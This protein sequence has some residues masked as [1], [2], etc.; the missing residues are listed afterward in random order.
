MEKN[1]K[2]NYFLFLTKKYSFSPFFSNLIITIFSWLN[3]PSTNRK[4]TIF[5]I[6]LSFL[7]SVITYLVFSN[8]LPYIKTTPPIAITTLTIDVI[9]LFALC[10]KVIRKIVQTWI[11]R[12]K[13]TV[14]AKIST[15]FMLTFALL[16]LIP[17]ITLATFSSLFFN[18]GMKGWFNDKILRMAEQSNIVAEAYLKEYRENIR[19]DALAMS[20]EIDENFNTI[21]LDLN[22]LNMY[23]YSQ[24]DLRELTEAFIFKKSGILLAKAGFTISTTPDLITDYELFEAENGKIILTSKRKD[25]VRALVKLKEIQNTYLSIGRF[26]D[27][28]IIEQIQNIK[29]ASMSYKKVF[30][31]RKKIEANFYMVF[32]LISLLILLI[33]I[34]IG[35]LF[36]DTLIKPITDLIKTSNKIKSGNLSV[37]VP[38][39]STKDEMSLLIKTF[40]EMTQKLKSQRIELKKRERNAAWSDIA[41]RIAH[42]I[43]NPLTPI[44]LSAEYLK[45]KSKSKEDKSYA[46]TII[47]KVSSIEDMVNEF[48]MFAK[49]PSPKF[50]TIKLNKLCSDLILFHKKSNKKIKFL[51]TNLNKVLIIKIDETQ[52]SMAISNLIQNSIE[53]INENQSK[54]KRFNGK[55]N[56]SIYLKKGNV[57][58]KIDDNGGGLP[59][60]FPKNEIL[61]PYITTKKKGSGLGLAIVLKII[62]EHNGNF[63]IN[64]KKNGTTALIELPKNI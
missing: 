48:S 26:I 31:E 1:L 59:K 13:G 27:P 53:S 42:E 39:I 8:S 61:E 33:S 43:K 21:F 54:N 32:I 41:R 12:K 24:I 16:V 40:N 37:K 62:Q 34:L 18:I 63:D 45:S 4:I 30:E 50:G 51:S 9:L 22:K 25:R 46:D 14:G 23:V 49:L 38:Q 6:I 60:N 15:K 20:K 58:I 7:A 44:Q 10:F 35:L 55:I 64:D 11:E 3:K 36:A 56:L 5:L 28:Q 19:K 2:K 47:K 17:T 29:D 52:I 57:Y